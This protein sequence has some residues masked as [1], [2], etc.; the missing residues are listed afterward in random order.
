MPRPVDMSIAGDG[1]LV[2]VLGELWP[3]AD[4]IALESKH[5]KLHSFYTEK[6]LNSCLTKM[7]RSARTSMEANERAG[8]KPACFRAVDI[9]PF[10]LMQSRQ[11]KQ[12][13]NF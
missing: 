9:R 6:E 5:K 3:F 13:G 4:F 7:Y 8:A 2:E 11:Q 12:Y 10:F 1:V